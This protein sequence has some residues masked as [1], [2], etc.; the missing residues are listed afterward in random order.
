MPPVAT[1]EELLRAIELGAAKAVP[2]SVLAPFLRPIREALALPPAE[3]DPA[4]LALALDQV[5]DLL[6]AFLLVPRP[7]A[8]GG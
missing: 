3:R 4:A 6:E 1:P 2:P 5:E 8:A 7:P